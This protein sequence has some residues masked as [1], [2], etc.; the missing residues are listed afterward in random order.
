M[1]RDTSEDYDDC[2][3]YKEQ[4]DR[5]GNLLEFLGIEDDISEEDAWQ[6]HWQ[7]MPAYDWKPSGKYCK[8]LLVNFLTE[9][10]IIKFSKLVDQQIS[11]KTKS[12]A[13]PALE[14]EENM[15]MRWVDDNDV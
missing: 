10:D 3:G 14:K 4:E 6:L 12:I 11:M 15:L 13:F 2:I 5:P 8:Q 9:E 7:D 1:S